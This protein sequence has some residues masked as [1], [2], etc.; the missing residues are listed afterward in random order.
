MDQVPQ[1]MTQI[2]PYG[3]CLSRRLFIVALVLAIFASPI[4]VGAQGRAVGTRAPEAWEAGVHFN[5]LS[6]IGRG[7]AIIF[8]PD[9]AP[10]GNREFYQALGFLYIEEASWQRVLNRI[11][12]RNYWHPDDPVQAIFLETHGT[13]G[14]GLK[15]QSGPSRTDGRSY[16]S[17][18]A[19]QEKLEGMGV[20][21]CV[22]AAC[23]SGRLFRPGT[24]K[25]IKPQPRDSLFLPATFGIINATSKFDPRL[26]QIVMARRR[27]SRIETT[28]EGKISEL[29]PMARKVSGFDNLRV[30]SDRVRAPRFVV[31]NLLIQMLLHD[32]RLKLAYGGYASERSQSDLTAAESEALFQRFIEYVNTVAERGDRPKQANLG[33]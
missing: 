19:L 29:S 12:A 22:I 8:S 25:T 4:R 14:D 9:I 16:I 11:I 21:L 28:S 31:S 2:P 33:R 32:P 1:T 20:K 24:Y 13:N 15:L 30:R 27:E 23:N 6:D 3:F 5:R 10:A 7:K 18:A 26:S 17:I